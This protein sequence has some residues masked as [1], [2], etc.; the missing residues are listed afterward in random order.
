VANQQ[1]VPTQKAGRHISIVGPLFSVAACH[2]FEDL[3]KKMADPE[4]Q[5][6]IWSSNILLSISTA[7]ILTEPYHVERTRHLTTC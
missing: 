3:K 7:S 6:N 4:A 5:T 1:M 2:E